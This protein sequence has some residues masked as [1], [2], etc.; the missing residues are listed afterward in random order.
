MSERT[1][2]AIG[3]IAAAVWLLVNAATM[4]VST[5]RTLSTLGCV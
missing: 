3:V 2:W 1:L 4:I 5:V